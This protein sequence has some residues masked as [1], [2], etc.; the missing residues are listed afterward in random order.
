MNSLIGT[1]VNII[2]QEQK[3][4]DFSYTA[5]V[6]EDPTFEMLVKETVGDAPYR[7]LLPDSMATAD[8][9]ENRVN[10][11]IK[12]VGDHYEVSRVFTG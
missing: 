8:Y 11:M 12:Q 10:I 3:A 5:R 7:L 9:V 4:G 2:E 1:R 6:I